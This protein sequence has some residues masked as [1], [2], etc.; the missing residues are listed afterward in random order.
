MCI[1]YVAKAVYRVTLLHVSL[2]EEFE[3]VQLKAHFQ[4]HHVTEDDGVVG[5]VCVLLNP[6]GS[7]LKTDP[8]DTVSSDQLLF[9]SSSS[10]LIGSHLFGEAL[11]PA[12]VRHR[13]GLYRAMQD[14]SD[15]VDETGLS[16]SNRPIEENSELHALS[17]RFIGFHLLQR[18]FSAAAQRDKVNHLVLTNPP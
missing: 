5:P 14:A 10:A 12:A 9:F 6:V 17:L 16:R 11:T 4:T 15:R 1:Y 18:F 2:Q 8:T 3:I 13:H 7:I